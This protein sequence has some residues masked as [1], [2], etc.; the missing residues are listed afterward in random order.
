[1]DQQ[2]PLRILSLDGGGIHGISSLYVLK[3]LMVQIEQDRR[4]TI[5]PL[6][7]ASLR[8]CEVFDLIEIDVVNQDKL[9]AG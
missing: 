7:A 2:K 6:P 5:L 8:P 9:E 4:A 3:E 1:M